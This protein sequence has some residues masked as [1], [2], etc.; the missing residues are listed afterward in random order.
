[1]RRQA[2]AAAGANLK[3]NCVTGQWQ[4]TP[5]EAK[6]LPDSDRRRRGPSIYTGVTN[7]G[8][9]ESRK[10]KARRAGGCCRS[11]LGRT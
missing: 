2:D 10:G 8:N 9:A 5:R 1:M 7:A 3:F 4:G 6:F 11:A